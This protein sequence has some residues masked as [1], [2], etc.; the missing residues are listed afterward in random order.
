MKLEDRRFYDSA[1][2]LITFVCDV[3]GETKPIP[4]LDCFVPICI[5]CYRAEIERRGDS[6]SG[7][8]A[9]AKGP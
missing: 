1:G 8:M 5:P 9:P 6:V 2:E 7:V 4:T 3:C